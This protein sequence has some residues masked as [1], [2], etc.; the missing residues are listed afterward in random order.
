M[1]KAVSLKNAQAISRKSAQDDVRKLTDVSLLDISVATPEKVPTTQ[2]LTTPH[3]PEAPSLQLDNE[4]EADRSPVVE[5]VPPSPTLTTPQQPQAPSTQS[6]ND[7]DRSPVATSPLNDHYSVVI[8]TSTAK[9]VKP[10]EEDKAEKELTIPEKRAVLEDQLK[11]LGIVSDVDSDWTD[12]ESESGRP[13]ILPPIGGRTGVCKDLATEGARK[14]FQLGKEAL[15]SSRTLKRELR[16]TAVE[17][18]SNLHDLVLSLADSRNRHKLNL[19]AEKLRAAKEMVRVERAHKKALIDQQREYEERLKET[20]NTMGM[21]HKA[22]EGLRSWLDFEMEALIKKSVKEVQ[23]EIKPA[24]A[25]KTQPLREYSPVSCP[26]PPTKTSSDAM[27]EVLKKLGDLANEIHYMKLDAKGDQRKVRERSE[28]PIGSP[29][30]SEASLDGIKR[31]IESLRSELVEVRALLQVPIPPTREEI[32]EDLN[33]ATAPIVRR[34]KEILEEVREVKDVA[35]TQGGPTVAGPV[36]LAAEMALTN[37]AAQIEDIINPLKA[38]VSEVAAQSK[39]LQKTLTWFNSSLKQ[40]PGTV[41]KPA[42]TTY[43]AAVKAP[44]RPKHALII[45][46]TDPTKTGDNVIET[47]RGTV[48]FKETGVNVDRVRKAKDRKVVLSCEREE[49][50][51]ILEEA[52]KSNNSLKV[53]QATSGNPQIR[54]KNVLTVNTDDDIVE[55][56]RAQNKKLFMDL[57]GDEKVLKVKYRKRAR[58]ALQCHPVLE[59]SP[60]LHKRLMEVGYVHIGLEKRP[61]EDQSP[62]VQCAKCLGFGHTKTLCRE[63]D[64]L[65]SYCGDNHLWQDCPNRKEGNPPSCKNCKRAKLDTE[66]PHMAFSPICPQWQQWDTI[67]RLRIAYC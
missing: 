26:T 32:K 44:P 54:I 67:A 41:A 59:V 37:T 19:E 39:A 50:A 65:C 64:Q 15:E 5:K 3:Q 8:S 27:A 22:V 11:E 16:A 17:C 49:D 31:G 38:N 10:E 9:Q 55:N 34:T 57:R 33:Q 13:S 56:L 14:Y 29:C 45:T 43:A 21:T 60:K 36:G 35:Y 58:N 42:P 28:S 1:R 24:A 4:E 23:Q 48:N 51:R 61:V 52:I 30:I 66:T 20:K 25:A 53:K 63:R 40:G 12:M 62:L 6:V 7:A 2:T 46:S 47:I 18:L